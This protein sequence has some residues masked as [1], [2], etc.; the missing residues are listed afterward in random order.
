MGQEVQEI[1]RSQ[2]SVKIATNGKGEKS[3]EVKAYGDTID[4]ALNLAMN[5]DK[6]LAEHFS[7]RRVKK[8]PRKDRSR[9]DL[10]L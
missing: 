9:Q 2:S 5:A 8:W 3:W 4:E 10:C 1:A 7:K 6:K